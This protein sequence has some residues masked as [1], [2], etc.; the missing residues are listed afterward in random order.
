LFL[1]F[2]LNFDQNNE[3]KHDKHATKPAVDARYSEKKIVYCQ[4]V[5]F[6]LLDERLNKIAKKPN[7]PIKLF[8]KTRF[9]MYFLVNM[10]LGISYLTFSVNIIL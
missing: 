4:R 3:Q 5:L 6:N 1:N 9:K 7:T 2:F 8:A 10:R